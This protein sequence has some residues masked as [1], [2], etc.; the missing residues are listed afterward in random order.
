[1]IKNICHLVNEHMFHYEQNW[2][3]AAVRRFIIRVKEECIEDLFDLRMADMY[4]MWNEKVDI[5]YSSAI[6]LL[7][8]LKERINDEL[9]KKT[10][11]SLKDLKIN[12]KDLIDIGFKPGKQL[13][14]ILEEL[15]NSVIEDPELNTKEKLLQIANSYKKK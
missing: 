5:K 11:L 15:F 4:G 7:L 9:E 12:G 8:E 14:Q 13:G 6:K 3:Q 2:T 10:A 1:M